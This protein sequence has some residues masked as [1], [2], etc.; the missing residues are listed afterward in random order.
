MTASPQE[1]ALEDEKGAVICHILTDVICAGKYLIREKNVNVNRRVKI[2]K[3]KIVKAILI[4]LTTV[5]CFLIGREYALY[6][7]G[8]KAVGGEYII[9]ISPAIAYLIKEAI[10][11]YKEAMKC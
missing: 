7:R 5:V 4:I 3:K 9:L 8:Y 6:D 10:K 1:E 2:M 11:D